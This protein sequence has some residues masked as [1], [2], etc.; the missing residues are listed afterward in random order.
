MKAAR[1]GRKAGADLDI[2][3]T[4]TL[5][6]D[7]C[8]QPYAYKT[9]GDLPLVHLATASTST[10]HQEAEATK[11]SRIFRHPYK[12]L[13][14]APKL[15]IVTAS[16]IPL[17]VDLGKCR[18]PLSSVAPSPRISSLLSLH[19]T[20]ASPIPS[21]VRTPR[22]RPVPP[23]V[24]SSFASCSIACSILLTEHSLFQSLGNDFCQ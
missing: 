10:H 6:D 2:Q 17:Q 11:L 5:A 16:A 24:S 22:F 23:A 3:E 18:K 4:G 15:S 19:V 13:P 12:R 1:T 8:R 20:T 7:S 14:V 21:F 9:R